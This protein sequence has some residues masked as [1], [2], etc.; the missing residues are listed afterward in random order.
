MADG[1]AVTEG[2]VRPFK[3]MT[4]PS[5]PWVGSNELEVLVPAALRRERGAEREL[6]YRYSPRVR[7]LALRIVRDT[8]DAADVVQET[9]ARAFR[10]LG[11]LP[12][13]AE[14]SP[15]LH[16]IAKNVSLECLKLRRRSARPL[17]PALLAPSPAP[18]PEHELIG[19]QASEALFR[20][21]SAL[22][23]E[24]RDALRLRVEQGL[25][26]Q[27]IADLLGWSLPKAKVEVHRAR[28]ALDAALAPRPKRARWLAGSAGVLLMLLMTTALVGAGPGEVPEAEEPAAAQCLGSADASTQEAPLSSTAC[29]SAAVPP[30]PAE[31]PWSD[32][33]VTKAIQA[34]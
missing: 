11:T 29:L 6:Y 10:G 30:A 8:H 4:V 24:R 5:A 7:S 25:A 12:H 32:A 20:A 3:G 23:A 34:P 19:R 21:L 22:P 2:A 14:F 18:S 31:I 15:W 28:R 9:F 27:E 33:P 16:G 1:W 17:P 13:P 26:Y